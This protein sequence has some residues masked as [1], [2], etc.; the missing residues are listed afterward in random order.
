[1]PCFDFDFDDD[2]CAHPGDD[3]TLQYHHDVAHSIKEEGG[4]LVEQ[5]A[6]N[7]EHGPT[8][9]AAL[10]SFYS[11]T[12]SGYS[13]SPRE[14]ASANS[15]AKK[16]ESDFVVA[17]DAINCDTTPLGDLHPPQTPT[18]EWK[19][20]LHVAV[21]VDPAHLIKEED[22][23]CHVD[24]SAY[25]DCKFDGVDD[26]AVRDAHDVSDEEAVQSFDCDPHVAGCT[27]ACRATISQAQCKREPV[28]DQSVQSAIGCSRISTRG[29]RLSLAKAL[30]LFPAD[31]LDER[32]LAARFGLMVVRTNE[33]YISYGTMVCKFCAASE[34]KCSKVRVYCWP[35]LVDQ[36]LQH[37]WKEHAEEWREFESLEEDYREAY[38]EGRLAPRQ[39]IQD[40]AEEMECVWTGMVREE[41]KAKFGV[42]VLRKERMRLRSDVGE[43]GEEFRRWRM[44]RRTAT[45][46]IWE[47]KRLREEVEEEE[48]ELARIEKLRKLEEEV[49]G[50]GRKE[51][52]ERAR[53]RGARLRDRE[54][55]RK[56]RLLKAQK[57]EPLLIV[58][59]KKE[60][61]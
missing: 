10:Q 54:K 19:R 37:L 6:H 61:G 11:N 36:M 51:D 31:K 33:M 29:E 16:E 60:G 23:L 34:Q 35:Y 26:V 20:E 52:E 58:H 45:K 57:E 22:E 3:S 14:E 53:R 24:D 47:R 46:R 18:C 4:V 7:E 15:R 39:V 5:H 8:D 59:E 12:A 43:E 28:E 32:E 56:D 1:M 21:A 50:N 44:E 27:R 40:R 42:E 2:V 41:T 13:S 55:R 49:N 48:E 9:T 17:H 38:F 25:N 30:H